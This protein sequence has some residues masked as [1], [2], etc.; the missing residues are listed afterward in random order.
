MNSIRAMMKALDIARLDNPGASP[1]EIQE[2][3]TDLFHDWTEEAAREREGIE[4]TPCLESCDT[5]TGEG[6]WHGV[7]G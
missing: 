3:A 1:D 7:I 2:I 6:R 4:D 5:G